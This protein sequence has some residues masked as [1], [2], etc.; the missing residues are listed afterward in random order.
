VAQVTLYDART[1][2]PVGDETATAP[3]PAVPAEHLSKVPF[4]VDP[5]EG[6]VFSQ[7]VV[8]PGERRVVAD[9]VPDADDT[10]HDIQLAVKERLEE[11]VLTMT[12]ADS[13]PSHLTVFHH[14]A[15]ADPYVPDPEIG[16]H[17]V[18]TGERLEVAVP[19]A[20]V[21]ASVVAFFRGRA[22]W[23]TAAVQAPDAG[24]STADV[25]VTIDPRYDE[26]TWLG[27]EESWVDESA[28]PDDIDI[29]GTDQ[30]AADATQAGDTGA[31]GGDA[32]VCYLFEGAT[33]ERV[34][35]AD[36]TSPPPERVAE[37]ARR[38][39]AE[40]QVLVVAPEAG[41]VMAR[42]ASTDDGTDTGLFAVY[43]NPGP[44]GDLLASFTQ[45]LSARS[46]DLETAFGV[47]LGDDVVDYKHL[48][49]TPSRPDP[50]GDADLTYLSRTDEP[51]E[52]AAPDA[53][54]ALGLALYL[55]SNLEGGRSV[56]VSAGGRTETLAGMDVVVA[57]DPDCDGVEALGETVTR[58]ADGRLREGVTGVGGTVQA[59]ADRVAEITGTAAAH[60]RVFAAALSGDAL[61]D[62]DLTV[63]PVD[64]NPLGRRRRQARY[65][66]LYGVVLVGVVAGTV[67]GQAA[68]LVALL[69]TTYPVDLAGQGSAVAVEGTVVASVCLLALVVG[70]Y[71]L[72]GYPLG[73]LEAARTLAKNVRKQVTGGAAGGTLPSSI[74]EAAD[75]VDEAIGELHAGYERLADVEGSVAGDA[76]GFGAF[77][78]EH[79]LTG[80][81]LPSV[82]VVDSEERRRELLEGIAVGTGVGT[83]AGGAVVGGLWVLADVAA[84]DPKL[85][86][87]GLVVLVGLTLVASLAKAALT[88]VDADR[89]PEWPTG[90]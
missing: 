82:A 40:G 73:P 90:R 6:R 15:A 60:Q 12:P 65:L 25:V 2:D 78:E 1:G 14:L 57:V 54:A 5:S 36:E 49:A 62:R 76:A 34:G 69:S 50:L 44:T 22:P 89:L 8:D 43:E 17:I 46:A 3:E 13:T 86:F 16:A 9:L 47:D 30:P 74:A 79:L 4:A 80:S 52:F 53:T 26:V 66:A 84:R 45:A 20:A 58:L 63:A 48:A 87:D 71:W 10:L 42:L 72:F 88:R 67:V 29:E 51:L 77:L 11:T 21:A 39:H 37:A 38:R 64:D 35:G 56:A 27:R 32:A 7:F 28:V 23:K 33:G 68:S 61:A 59:L 83:L 18:S 81:D 55:R 31:A 75:P 85:V 19:D 70:A 41:V 24:V